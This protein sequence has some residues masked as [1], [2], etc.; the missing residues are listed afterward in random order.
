MA[1]NPTFTSSPVLSK[2]KI[3]ESVYYLKDADL[4]AIVSAF[5]NATAQDVAVEIAENGTGLATS[6]QVYDFVLD[7]TANIAGAMHFKS[8]TRA[9]QTNPSAGDIVL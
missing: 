9:E 1:I 2:V 7:R 8:G 6:A 5:G 4:R 3:G